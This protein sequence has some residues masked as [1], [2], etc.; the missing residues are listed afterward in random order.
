[1]GGTFFLGM[2]VRCNAVEIRHFVLR[3]LADQ[4]VTILPKIAEKSGK[5]T[6]DASNANLN[7]IIPSK[8]VFVTVCW[9]Q[10]STNS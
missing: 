7:N 6:V 2:Y 5:K 4:I 3:V 8:A 10:T 1:M 9:P